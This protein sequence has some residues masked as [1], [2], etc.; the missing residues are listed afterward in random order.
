MG[1]FETEEIEAEED[2]D[3]TSANDRGN[4]TK[5]TCAECG[6]ECTKSF[7]PTTSRYAA[8]TAIE[9]KRF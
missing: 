8:E 4:R 5:A 1:N 6:Q 9:E 3:P 2:S 7:L